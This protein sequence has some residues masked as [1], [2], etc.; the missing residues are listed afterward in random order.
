MD[1]MFKFLHAADLHL[2]SPLQGLPVYEG[3]PVEQIRVAARRALIKLVDLSISQSVAFLLIA[4]DVYD[5]S[6]KDYNTGHFFNAQM[7][8]L[9]DA[10]I[11]VFLIRGNHDS[12][13]EITRTLRLPDNVIE[14]STDKPQTIRLDAF[15]VSIHGQGFADR[16]VKQNLVSGYP[17]A[18]RGMLNIGM[19]HTSCTGREGHATYA[20][21]SLEDLRLLEY[22]Y[23]ALGHIHTREQLAGDPWIIFPGNLQGRHIRECGAKGATLVTVSDGTIRSVQHHDL[24]VLR[25]ELC[26]VNAGNAADAEEVL[27]RLDAEIQQHCAAAE[28]RPLAM[29]VVVEGVCQAHDQ[30]T[31]DIEQWKQEAR[32]VATTVGGGKVW[33]EQVKIRTTA[34]T[35]GAS[36][37]ETDGLEVDLAAVLA[38]LAQNDE[39]LDKAAP[40]LADLGKRLPRDLQIGSDAIA[41]ADRNY[42]RQLLSEVREALLPQARSAGEAGQ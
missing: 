6:W 41:L 22:D 7:G 9:R 13:S 12:Q 5:G 42:L 29:R 1:R 20:P 31:G 2:D 8:R 21:C 40:E 11:P 16:E 35:V 38:E 30:L 36:A 34:P 26:R 10:K 14:L 23:W 18:D 19:L 39:L 33:I 27:A 28:G 32:S 17:P 24:D 25:W 37:G 4:G 3:A 15:N